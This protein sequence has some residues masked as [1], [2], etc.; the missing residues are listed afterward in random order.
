MMLSPRRSYPF[1]HFLIVVSATLVSTSFIVWAAITDELD[2]AILTFV[3]FAIASVLFGPWVYYKYGA[4]FSLALFLRCSV[5]SSCLVI[6]F[7]CMFFSLRY[8]TPLNTSVI[9]TLVP[10][11]SGFYALFLVGERLR[12]EQLIALGCGMIGA[13]WVIFRGDL[14][15][16]LAME[17]NKGDL[18]FLAGGCVLGLYAPLVQLLHRDEPMAV[19]T[20]WVLV[21]GGLWLLFFNVNKLVALEWSSVSLNVWGGVLYLAV[22]T[23]IVTFFLTQYA[24]P[25]LGPTL[26]TSYSYLYPG[27]VLLIQLG[28]GHGLP[29]LSVIPGVVIVLAAMFIIQHSRK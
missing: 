11:I 27:L 18:I 14:T 28:L 22:F 25:Y 29:S 16:F 15:A 4:T 23:T 7:W 12:R 1:I 13:I 2:P 21:T 24:I 6:F 10:S 26:V 3:R 17:W 5:I 8:T 20:F 9:F 19:M